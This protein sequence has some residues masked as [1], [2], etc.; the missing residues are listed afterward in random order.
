[1]IGGGMQYTF[2]LSQGIGVGNSPVEKDPKIA[3]EILA[4]ADQK[5]VTLKLPLDHLIATKVAPDAQTRTTERPGIPDGWE[6]V[7]IG[8]KTIAAYPKFLQGARTILWNGPMGVFEIEPFSKGTRAIAQTLA[9]MKGIRVVGGGDTAA[10]VVQFRLADRM[11]HVSTGG[12]ASLEYLEG[13]TLP[14][15]AA[16]TLTVPFPNV[17]GS[18]A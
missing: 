8:P 7:D 14:G 13:K 3:Q 16:L 10:A 18:R 15:V 2:F 11:T 17:Q 6:G 1:L 12:G 9:G 4:K 5:G